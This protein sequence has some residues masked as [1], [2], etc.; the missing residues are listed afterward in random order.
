MKK[1][2][3]LFATAGVLLVSTFALAACGGNKDASKGNDGGSDKGSDTYA[4]VF[5]ADITSLDYTFTSKATNGDH[6]A[7]FVTGL[8]EQDRFGNMVPSVA[9]D[10][11]VSKDGLK[12]TYKIRKGVKWVDNQGND[13]GDVKAQDFV[14]GLKHAA[15]MQSETLYIVADSVKGLS[16]YA[17]GKITDFSQVGV[18]ALDDYT[19]EYTLNRPESFWN[20]KLNYGVLFPVQ[21]DFL[22]EKGEKFGAA[23]A[24]SILYNGPYVLSNFTSKSIIEYA[25]NDAYWDKDNVHIQNVKLTYSDGSDPDSYY[26]GFDDGIYAGAR[27][28]PNS[29]AFKDVEEKY[30]DDIIWSLPGG[31]TFNATFN[32]NRKTYNA[33]SK[34][35]DKQKQDTQ[36]AILNK[37]FR[38]AIQFAFNK[39]NYQ[40]QLNG[41][42]GADAALRNMLIPD[43]FV[44]IAGKPYYEVVEKDLKAM[45]PVFKDVKLGQAQEGYY[46]EAVAKEVFAK[47]KEA[48]QKENVEFPI[49]LDLPQ[50][51]TQELLVNQ[52]KSLKKSVEDVLGADNVVIDIQLLTDDAMNIATYQAPNGASSDFDIS[53]ASGW[54]ADF[55]DPSSYLDI[56]QSQ[57]GSLLHTLGL[58]VQ[59]NYKDG[60]DP[61]AEAKKALHLD[62]YDKLL[63]DA[64]A[65]IDDPDARYTAYAKAEAWLLENVLQIPIHANGG[66]PS[67]TKSVPFV[68]SYGTTGLSNVSYKYMELS[69]KP[70]SKKQYDE[71]RAKWEKEKEEAT[72][73]YTDDL[74]NKVK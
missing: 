31:S 37:E 27:V 59:G 69:D 7:S 21:E 57:N 47:A 39:T 65:I 72:K 13:H 17:T 11:S 15:D 23:E 38:Q 22:K 74:A 9:E 71:S 51:E 33:T 46:N 64:N 12:Y 66:A 16:D 30:G 53:T 32:F 24:D 44:S 42:E 41:K 3:K 28:F 14:T 54:G 18:K 26:K 58:E 56:Y 10:W 45:N 67:L 49:H 8:L 48:L 52:S 19:V 70:I 2:T 34:T 61:S 36:K 68:K 4:Y 5:G 6:L 62:E 25:A 43:D 35:T 50:K 29:P 1:R 63:A 40:A 20:S 60:V 55:V 73:K